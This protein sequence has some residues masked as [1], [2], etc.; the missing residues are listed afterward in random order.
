MRNQSVPQIRLY[1]RSEIA[2][3]EKSAR[4]AAQILQ[5]I[6]P[7][8]VPGVST[9]SLDQQCAEAIS[10]AGAIAAPLN[11][12]GFPK[13]ICTSVNNVVCHGIPSKDEILQE[14]DI[15]N[16]DITVI[17]DG[18]HGDTS[19]TFLVGDTSNSTSIFVKRVESAMLRGIEA[20]EAGRRFNVIGDAI[21]KYVKKFGYSV[22]REYCG[23]G[24]GENF[25]EEPAV[26]HY[27][28]KN[29]LPFLEN[30]MVF[31]VEPMINQNRNWRTVL[32]PQDRWTAR[33]C[34]GALSAQ[35]EHT[36]AIESGKARILSLPT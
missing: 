23:H 5:D 22:V 15:V 4:L 20:V 13:H 18:Y 25:H 31:T 34:D 24:I 33:T 6:E 17:L 28:A 30:G 16:I 21:E 26:L 27:S 10:S 2:S 11:Y 1:S 19:R 9:E 3:I 14:G 32:D 7:Q 35:F 29:P 8:V 12:R 36:I